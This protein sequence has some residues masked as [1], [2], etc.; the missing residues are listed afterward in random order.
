M[1][2]ELHTPPPSS[3]PACMRR[4]HLTHKWGEDLYAAVPPPLFAVQL[5][6]REVRGILIS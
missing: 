3:A 4:T 2:V 5:L 1:T 6:V